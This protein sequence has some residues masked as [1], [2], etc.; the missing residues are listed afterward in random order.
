MKPYLQFTKS[1]YVILRKIFVPEQKHFNTKELSLFKVI[2][3]Y[4]SF[5]CH[6]NSENF[7]CVFLTWHTKCLP[8]FKTLLIQITGIW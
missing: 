7:V 5:S 1:K 6:N 3:H 4:L 2:S 8:N